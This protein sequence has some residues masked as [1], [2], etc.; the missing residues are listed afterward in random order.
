MKICSKLCCCGFDLIIARD[1]MEIM[2]ILPNHGIPLIHPQ[3]NHIV[4]YPDPIMQ[5]YWSSPDARNPNLNDARMGGI[6]DDVDPGHRHFSG[7][8]WLFPSVF[9]VYGGNNN[10]N[11]N[12]NNHPRNCSNRI[13]PHNSN[14]LGHN[15]YQAA[16]NTLKKKRLHNGGH[17]SWS[18]AWEASLYARL[19]DGENAK[20]SLDHIL[21]KYMTQNLLSLHP[22]L[23][24]GFL[25]GCSTCF[26][27]SLPP[28]P[29]KFILPPGIPSMQFL[30]RERGLVTT[31]QS[32]VN[33]DICFYIMSFFAI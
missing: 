30:S 2:K 27:E 23:Q 7:M 12:S 32:K 5:Q 15:L 24:D 13:H 16:R 1:F 22:P 20:L 26:Q 14:T 8:H 29:S 6:Q 9:M 25:D 18:A 31:T 11:N 4:E 19:F 28:K 17:T 21:S 3:N 33:Y 10:N